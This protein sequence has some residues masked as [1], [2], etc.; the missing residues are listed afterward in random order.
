MRFKKSPQLLGAGRTRV[1]HHIESHTPTSPGAILLSK[2]ACQPKHIGRQCTCD[3]QKKILEMVL[4]GSFLK[5]TTI[6]YGTDVIRNLDRILI[7]F[8]KSNLLKL[9][10]KMLKVHFLY[11]PVATVLFLS[12][13]TIK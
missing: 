10:N 1:G 4:K 13:G 3:L 11:L 12:I 2:M 7:C 9:Q 8:S 6:F 5:S